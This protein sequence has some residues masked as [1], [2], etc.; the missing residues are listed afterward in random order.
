MNTKAEGKSYVIGPRTLELRAGRIETFAG[1][2]VLVSSDDNYLSHGGGVSAA[3][4][5][6]AGPELAA[7]LAVER[8][9]LR[10][11]SV[12]TTT[13]GRLP[14]KHLLHAVTI[15]FDDSRRLGTHDAVA[16]YGRVMDE[17]ARL[18][19]A[20]VATPLLGAGTGTLGVASS[21]VALATAM[22]ERETLPGVVIRVVLLVLEDDFRIVLR[23]LDEHGLVPGNVPAALPVAPADAYDD[24]A[25]LQQFLVALV[26]RGRTLVEDA[27]QEGRLDRTRAVDPTIGTFREGKFEL[28]GSSVHRSPHTLLRLAEQL[29]SLAGAPVSRDLVAAVSDANAARNA[30]AH[31]SGEGERGAYLRDLSRGIHALSVELVTPRITGA[32]A[33]QLAAAS[34]AKG[35]RSETLASLLALGSAALAIDQARRSS[36]TASPE[37]LSADVKADPPVSVAEPVQPVPES[38]PRPNDVPSGTQHVRKLQ[39][40]LLQTLESEDIDELVQWLRETHRYRGDRDMCLLE[41]C[42]SVKDPIGFLAHRYTSMRLREELKKRTGEQL[43]IDVST[44]EA[45]SRLL[46]YFG[47]PVARPVRGLKSVRAQL[48][49]LRSMAADADRDAL[50]GGVVGAG[51]QLEYLV[52]VLLRFVCTVLH[53]Q[54]AELYFRQL[55]QLE[56]SKSLDK[57]SLGTLLSLLEIL[58]KELEV[59]SGGRVEVFRLDFGTDRLAPEG[60]Q[61][62]AALRNRF[63]HF[64]R[65]HVDLPLDAVRAAARAFYD[66]AAAF[67]D[68]L[69]KPSGR[70]FPYLVTIEQVETDKWGRCVIRAINDEGAEERIF[71]DTPLRPGDTYFMH[72]LT[73][74]LRVDPILVPAGELKEPSR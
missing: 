46:E 50:V 19:Q 69:G 16:L 54:P 1:A 11:G 26:E 10:L 68:H 70:V 12:L 15:D 62:I 14:T 55:G 9:R 22:Q 40:F 2:G 7:A 52:L 24:I 65:G 66:E 41:H 23:A 35:F 34:V 28:A 33:A 48:E 57:C 36:G 30:L 72:P 61:G 18:G 27:L 64:D 4:W 20:V 39:S 47:Y 74:P 51:S 44:E 32:K 60:A 5:R 17:T 3:L 45:A 29:H 59:T 56:V 63:A 8:P 67:L 58:A 53:E 71:T 43:A 6:A 42:V 13:A 21:A 37:D 31:N 73:N 49:N 25:R 38:A